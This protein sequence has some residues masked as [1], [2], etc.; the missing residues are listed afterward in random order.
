MKLTELRCPS[1]GGM[2][3]INNKTMIA[4]C[5]NCGTYISLEWEDKNPAS[6][7]NTPYQSYPNQNTGGQ[8]YKVPYSQK[9][10][11]EKEYQTA[12]QQ[13]FGNVSL[14]RR[15]YALFGGFLI[16]L[17]FIMPLF[18]KKW[19]PNHS[20]NTT[21]EEQAEGTETGLLEEQGELPKIEWTGNLS[22]LAV[23][24]F[25][26]PADDVSAED[27]AKIKW[28]EMK[29]VDDYRMIGYSFDSPEAEDAELTWIAFPDSSDMGEECLCLF[30]GLEKLVM[31]DS[32]HAEDIKGL[33]L[34]SLGGYFDSPAEVDS[35]VEDAA[36][37]KE[38]QFLGGV[39]SLDGMEQFSGLERLFILSSELTEVDAL[40]NVPN[41]KSLELSHFDSLSDFSVFSTLDKLEEL[42]LDAENLRALN[43]L[44]GMKSLKRLEIKSGMMIS[45]DGVE[46]RPELEVLSVLSCEELKNMDAVLKLPNL[47]ELALELP[48]ECSEPNLSK[49][50]GLEHLTLDGFGEASYLENLSNLQ[51]LELDSCYFSKSPDLSNLKNLKELTYRFF[52]GSGEDISFIKKLPALEKLNMSG[53][54]TYDDIS[55]IFNMKNLKEL[56]ISGME[57]E[58][59]FDR[60]AENETL[61]SLYMNDIILYENVQVSYD[62]FITYV[63]WD[64][65]VLDEHTAFLSR[66]KGLKYLSIQTNQLTDI[67]F[68]TGMTMLETIDLTDNYVTELRPLAEL[69][70]LEQVIC[71]GNPI[72]NKNVLSD[73]VTLIFE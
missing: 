51:S 69:K 48:Y 47:K 6:S 24:V 18:S 31:I 59:D 70:N 45:L 43:F 22:E 21:K 58:I 10:N 63:E 62:G 39:K 41:L 44:G 5:E 54:S 64:D 30:T 17:V 29:Y 2:L 56:K 8:F 73:K 65:V 25:G 15:F 11:A 57:C 14:D 23:S 52:S 46:D 50:T 33:K 9:N 1:C 42:S 67:S 37:I 19:E 12:S 35:I 34:T 71:T 3:N 13:L 7:Q 60:I 20:S 68:V 26:V 16:L 66:L 61:E 55:G 28:L 53:V 72:S 49:L 4:Q 27:L 36:S 40:R 38:L 32:I